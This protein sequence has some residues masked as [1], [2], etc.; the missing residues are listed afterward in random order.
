MKP[1]LDLR[2]KKLLLEIDFNARKSYA[3]LAKKLRMS[4]RGVEYK[5]RNLEKKKIILGYS[6]IINAPKLGYYY[7][8]VFVK[9][10]NLTKEVKEKIEEYMKNHDEVGWAIWFYGINGIGFV[11]WAKTLS[12]FREKINN[13]YSE[14]HKNIQS[15]FESIGIEIN[16]YKN[17]YLLNSQ[18]VEKIT[19]KE[20]TNKF[21]LD[22]IDKELLRILIEDPRLKIVE[23]ASK[24]KESA[25]TTAYRLKRLYKNEILLGIRPILNHSLL[26]KTYYK[27]YI[28]FL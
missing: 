24:L 14:F 13:F 21:K 10:Q 11:S 3:E 4:K 7:C 8:R 15:R 1:K 27:V 12:D 20:R 2:D 6:P 22:K 28:T 25:R 5:L 18:D 9:F 16:F 17:R 19:L 26:G 23:I